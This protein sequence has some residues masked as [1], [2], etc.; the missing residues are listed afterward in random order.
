MDKII[1]ML[2]I[3]VLYIEWA[4]SSEKWSVLTKHPSSSVAGEFER[5]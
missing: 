2:V 4:M 3:K 5:E 1:K